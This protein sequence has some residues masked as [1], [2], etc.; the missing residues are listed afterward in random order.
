MPRLR[1][2]GAR[3]VNGAP[4]A[5]PARAPPPAGRYPAAVFEITNGE[6]SDARRVDK[7][8][9]LWKITIEPDGDDDVVVTLPATTS[10]S[11]TGAV[12]N[13]TS[14]GKPSQPLSRSVTATVAGPQP[15]PILGGD[16]GFGLAFKADALWVGT[17]TE[18]ASGATG[19]LD[20]TRAGVTRLRTAVERSQT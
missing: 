1:H 11:A 20:S 13:E 16:E 9:D 4:E 17:R 12:C 3:R 10:C 8:R 7:R 14:Q 5:C 6:I 18:A 15:D 2:S 19:N